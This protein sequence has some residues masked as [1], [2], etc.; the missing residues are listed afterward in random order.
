V[1]AGHR[2]AAF[3]GG[4][5]SA[6]QL[7]LMQAYLVSAMTADRYCTA[8]T[9][10]RFIFEFCF[11]FRAGFKCVEALG[12]IIIRGPYPPS[13]ALIYTQLQL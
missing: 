12:M 9:G 2:E 13:N 3:D 6:Q 4:R 8:L 11:L 1:A 7:L 5:L 10:R